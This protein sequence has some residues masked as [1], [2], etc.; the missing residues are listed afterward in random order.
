MNIFYLFTNEDLLVSF[1]L[2]CVTFHIIIIIIIII[3][4][5]VLY[6]LLYKDSKRMIL[7]AHLTWYVHV[8]QS[9]LFYPLHLF[10]KQN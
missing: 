9:E 6:V 7:K 4:Y 5:N 10:S 2:K 3:I 1:V 8:F